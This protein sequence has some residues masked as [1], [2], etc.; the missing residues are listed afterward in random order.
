MASGME[1]KVEELEHLAETVENIQIK[2]KA[3]KVGR[4]KALARRKELVKM[5]E[6]VAKD[7][8]TNS[9]AQVQCLNPW[10]DLLLDRRDKECE[11]H[12]G[13]LLMFSKDRSTFEV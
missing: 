5:V 7:S 1:E 11:F 10:A 13:M 4:E 8:F 6:Q 3:A 12:N 9:F 2:L